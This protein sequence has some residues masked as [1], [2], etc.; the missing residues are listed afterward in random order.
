MYS[1]KARELRRCRATRKDGARCQGWAVWQDEQGRCAGHGGRIEGPHIRERTRCTPCTCVAYPWPH[2]PGSGLC[3]WPDPPAYRL[4]IRE[5]T[6]ATGYKAL[7]SILRQPSPI[8]GWRLWHK[9]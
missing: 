6:H 7:H 5:G 9:R 1:E 3:L 4:N 2:R 8:A